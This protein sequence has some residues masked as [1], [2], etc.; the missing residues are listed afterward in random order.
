[1]PDFSWWLA[2]KLKIVEL[3]GLDRD[4]LHIYSAVIIQLATSWLLR[5]RLREWR[6]LLPLLLFELANEAVDLFYEV[7]PPADRGLQWWASVHDV[8]NTLAMP[9]VLVLLARGISAR[10]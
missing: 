1:M 2:W 8:L 10:G 4:A 5:W 3:G 9:V 6:T 7:W